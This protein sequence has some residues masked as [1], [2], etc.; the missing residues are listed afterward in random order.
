MHGAHMHR[1]MTKPRL[2]TELGYLIKQNYAT[3][4]GP[5][6]SNVAASA[7][8]MRAEGHLASKLLCTRC[9]ISH[10]A[11]QVL[12]GSSQLF[13]HDS[14]LTGGNLKQLNSIKPLGGF[15]QYCKLLEE[16]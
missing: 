6:G 12:P 8:R 4:A 3:C 7:C 5:C 15:N 16:K 1:A 2:P 11:M 10:P 13:E 14:L 9:G